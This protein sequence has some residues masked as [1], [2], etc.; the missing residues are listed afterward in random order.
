MDGKERLW[1]TRKKKNKKK[2]R[3]SMGVA[4]PGAP[5]GSTGAW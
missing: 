5:G 2:K 4:T 1:A 3:R